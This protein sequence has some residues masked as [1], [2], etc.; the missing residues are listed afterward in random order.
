MEFFIW[1]YLIERR[2][3]SCCQVD[4]WGM[5]VGNDGGDCGQVGLTHL[6]SY[7]QYT[8]THTLHPY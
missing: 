1:K 3:L 5:E 6:Y 8:H 4:V 7:P 2:R